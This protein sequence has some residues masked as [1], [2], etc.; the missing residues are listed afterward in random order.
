MQFI[1]LS[2]IVCLTQNDFH[3]TDYRTW[4]VLWESNY[5]DTVVMTSS[6]IT[7]SNVLSCIGT[8]VHTCMVDMSALVALCQE[9]YL[10][11]L[12]SGSRDWCTP[13]YFDTSV[14]NHFNGKSSGRVSSCSKKNYL[15]CLIQGLLMY[16]IIYCPTTLELMFPATIRCVV[17]DSYCIMVTV[18]GKF[19]VKNHWCF[20]WNWFLMPKY[21][22]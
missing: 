22:H 11:P 15:H 18:R 6:S 10:V 19:V 7:T 17:Q 8:N 21:D 3:W 9:E 14:S 12:H 2:Q 13:E 5:G 20:Q 16:D 1:F 4:K